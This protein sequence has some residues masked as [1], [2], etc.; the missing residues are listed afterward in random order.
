MLVPVK[1]PI[2]VY[3]SVL[4]AGPNRFL[5]VRASESGVISNITFDSNHDK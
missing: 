2:I 3:I 4:K 5:I 1:A